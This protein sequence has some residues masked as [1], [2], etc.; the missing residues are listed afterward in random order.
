[1]ASIP[2]YR[3]LVELIAR[4]NPA[5]ILSYKTTEETLERVQEL[6]LKQSAGTLSAEEASELQYFIYLENMLGLA[7]AQAYELSKAA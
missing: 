7:K 1:M 3:E 4:L 2:A 5:L 6:V